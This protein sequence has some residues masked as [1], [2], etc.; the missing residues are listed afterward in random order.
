MRALWPSSSYPCCLHTWLCFPSEPNPTDFHTGTTKNQHSTTTV[1]QQLAPPSP[2]F[3]LVASTRQIPS[4]Y[5]TLESLLLFWTYRKELQ[6]LSSGSNSHWHLCQY[7]TLSQPT[8]SPH[9]SRG[10]HLLAKTVSIGSLYMQSPTGLSQA[11]LKQYFPTFHYKIFF[12][13]FPPH[14]FFL[15]TL[16]APSK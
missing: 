6:E 15:R 4:T 16:Q 3:P 14:F 11:P 2:H 13:L 9:L 12:F 8:W 10:T 7:A 5:F 1:H